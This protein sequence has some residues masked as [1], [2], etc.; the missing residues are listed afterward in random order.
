MSKRALSALAWR[1]KGA[2]HS[3]DI[4]AALIADV[5]NQG[6]DHV[7]ITGD[8]T[9]FSTP[10]ELAAAKAWL[11]TLGAAADVTVS[12]GN[13]DALITA[14]DT[15]FEAWGPW[16]GDE[17]GEEFPKVRRR[18]PL[19]LVNL[20]SATPTQPLLATG[21]LGAAQLGRLER[22]LKDLASETLCRVVTLHH[23]P[24]SGVVSGRKS[25]EDGADL[26]R[27]LAAHG[28]ELVLHGHAHEAIT[29]VLPG[30][31]GPIPV[32]GAPSASATPG[33]RH[34]PARWHAIEIDPDKPRAGLRIVARGLDAETGA[35]VDLGAYRL[36]AVQRA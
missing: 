27:L 4:L 2:G 26:R 3:P 19:A 12:P 30:P 22:V 33:H 15:A 8:L 29:S 18:G 5:R 32:L 25:L 17:S 35:F 1:R 9:N 10:A 13:H 36:P 11:Q 34:P 28:A 24:V 21:R 6:A 20:C 23:P 7:A 31:N 14:P 16:L